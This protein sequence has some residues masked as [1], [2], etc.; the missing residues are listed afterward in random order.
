VLWVGLDGEGL[1]RLDTQRQV[2]TRFAPDPKKTGALT[3]GTVRALAMDPDG[4]LWVGTTGGGLHRLAPQARPS[5]H[6]QRA[7]GALPD[8]RVQAL[9]V[10]RRGDLW[11]GTWNGLV[12]LRTRQH[13]ALSPCWSDPSQPGSLAGR[14]V[15][16]LGEAPDGRI[17]AG[18]RQGDLVLIDPATGPNEWC[19]GDRR[20]ACP[21]APWS[22]HGRRDMGQWR[23][24][25][26]TA[27]CRRRPDCDAP[28]ARRAKPWGLAANNVVA[29]LRERSGSLWAGSYGGGLQ[30]QQP[31]QR[32]CGC[33]MAKWTTKVLSNGDTRSLHQLRNGEIWVG[34]SD[35][36]VAVLDPAVAPSW[37]RFGPDPGGKRRLSRAARWAPSPSRP[38][39]RCGWAPKAGSTSSARNAS[40]CAVP[41]PGRAA[42]GACWPRATAASGWAHKTAST[43]DARWRAL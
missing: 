3:N 8:D 40:C 30:R 29:V 10:D 33:A 35:R 4:A 17:W 42:P 15:T 6:T 27:Q 12:R 34:M 41:A 22:W 31:Q 39:D 36:G 24:R 14:I 16:M 19:A 28:A 11:V 9:L 32:G 38:M 43:G 20:P 25:R 13:R 18:T 7:S 37:R 1:A 2:W 5:K 23:Q 26:P 21:T